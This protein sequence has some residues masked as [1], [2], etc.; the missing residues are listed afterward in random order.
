M[1][2]GEGVLITDLGVELE[3]VE[4]C[5]NDLLERFEYRRPRTG[6]FIELDDER[7]D[8]GSGG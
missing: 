6:E 8:T 1:G 3:D 4:F 7:G 5:D 2:N